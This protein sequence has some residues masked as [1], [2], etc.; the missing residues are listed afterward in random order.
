[1]ASALGPI[2][3]KLQQRAAANAPAEAGVKSGVNSSSMSHT[4]QIRLPW[5]MGQEFS[6]TAPA[7]H[8]YRGRSLSLNPPGG[9]QLLSEPL[10]I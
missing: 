1:M 7:Q 10:T 5:H 9:K 4:E 2:E 3:S 6:M 8:K